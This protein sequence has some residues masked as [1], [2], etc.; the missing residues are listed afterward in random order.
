MFD[1]LVEHGYAGTSM[2]AV[3]RRAKV[4]KA[5]LYRRWGSKREMYL[6]SLQEATRAP[7]GAPDTGSLYGDLRAFMLSGRGLLDPRMHHFLPELLALCVRDEGFRTEL[8]ASLLQPRRDLV[9]AV[10]RRAIE[11]GE[12]RPDVDLELACDLFVGPVYWRHVLKRF[13]VTEE[14]AGGLAQMVVLALGGTVPAE[15]PAEEG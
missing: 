11:A 2:E 3:A 8:E 4:G 6:S 10:F 5:A 12:T 9:R 14:S 15:G 7:T 1:E 13:P